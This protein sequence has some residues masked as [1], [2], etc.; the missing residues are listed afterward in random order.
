MVLDWVTRTA[1]GGIPT[2]I[3]WTL[4]TR[5]D[6]LEYADDLC[7]FA[8]RLQDIRLKTEAL[9]AAANQVG[10]HIN[11]NKTKVMRINSRQDGPVTVEGN[12]IEDVQEFTYLGSLVSTT[13]G[14]D[15]DVR[16][17]IKKARQ[18]FAQLR[19]VWK[20]RIYSTNV[21]LR[22][23]NSNVKSVLLYG[24]ETW[25]LTK[26]IINRLQVFLNGCLRRIL[27]VRWFDRIS[28]KT[29]WERASQDT[30]EVQIR[31]RKW[32]WIGHTLRKS[33]T[34][35]TKTSLTWNPQG[36][37]KRG[38]P[39]TSW[40]RTTMAELQGNNMTWQQCATTSQNRVRWRAV[41][42]ALCHARGQED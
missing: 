29:I 19:P 8:H 28:N 42:D 37:R 7:L 15:E 27:N 40:R 13:G 38:R 9:S 5:L 34:N 10:L 41:V 26:T 20:S 18:V 3:R 1:Y 32:K 25:R 17:R 14:T 33:D 12:P 4:Q 16:T 2:G 6:D 39:A 22:I 21:K 36:Q 24:S 31:K 11:T 35:V 23:F 30:I